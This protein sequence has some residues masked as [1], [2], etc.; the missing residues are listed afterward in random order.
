MPENEFQEQDLFDQEKNYEK[1]LNEPTSV[2]STRS[3][4]PWTHQQQNYTHNHAMI[5]SF[6]MLFNV[7][8]TLLPML[9]NSWC[10]SVHLP[11]MFSGLDNHERN[12]TEVRRFEKPTR[13]M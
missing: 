6:S 5:Y 8:F 3:Q 7:L 10:G 11:L 9:S 1:F 2:S 13:I 4:Q 12:A